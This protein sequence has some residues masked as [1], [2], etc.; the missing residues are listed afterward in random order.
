MKAIYKVFNIFISLIILC[1]CENN[2]NHSIE[3]STEKVD[4]LISVISSLE[5]EIKW[6]K[7]NNPFVQVIHMEATTCMIV[8]FKPEGLTIKLNNVKPSF[9]KGT[10]LCVPAAFTSPQH[11]VEGYFMKEGKIINETINDINGFIMFNKQECV[12]DSI[13]Y[14]TTNRLKI[15]K[16]G[17]YNIFQQFLLIKKSKLVKCEKFK[18]R[19]NTRRAIVKYP[20]GDIF[21]VESHRPMTIL[22][23]QEALVELGVEDALYLDMGT[24]SEGWYKS[25]EH[26]KIKIG[27]LYSNTNKQTNWLT[28]ERNEK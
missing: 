24:Y 16:E 9:N 26:E 10:F 1:S 4:S 19:I 15:A 3:S 20:E 8:H 23:F 13:K 5:G 6:L 7:K 28:F 27:E 2:R 25:F 21:I 17:N 11:E 14:L 12:I 18:N 22:E